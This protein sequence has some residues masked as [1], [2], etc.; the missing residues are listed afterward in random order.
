MVRMDTFKDQHKAWAMFQRYQL[1]SALVICTCFASDGEIENSFIL[2]GNNID[3]G[4]NN[5]G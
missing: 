4:F 2:S 5:F 1:V 3:E